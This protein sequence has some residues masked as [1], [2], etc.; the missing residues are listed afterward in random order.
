MERVYF[1]CCL[2]GYNRSSVFSYSLLSDVIIITVVFSFLP[3]PAA[4]IRP[5]IWSFIC[6]D[7]RSTIYSFARIVRPVLY[8]LLLM[9]RDS[10]NQEIYEAYTTG[11]ILAG[12]LR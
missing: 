2:K 1:F 12:R 3:D 5:A 8:G 10:I 6:V 9:Y 7:Y 4:W 11:F